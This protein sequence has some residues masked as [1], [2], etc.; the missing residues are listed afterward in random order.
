MAGSHRLWAVGH[1]GR[2][3]R[4]SACR[5]ESGM[6]YGDGDVKMDLGWIGMDWDGFG[7]DEM[8]DG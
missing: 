2:A 1:R 7:M 8:M 3:E 5:P 6:W 4:E